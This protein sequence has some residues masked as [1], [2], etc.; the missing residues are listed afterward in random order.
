MEYDALNWKFCPKCHMTPWVYDIVN[1]M[2]GMIVT[3]GKDQ[4]VE[5]TEP[6]LKDYEGA[7]TGPFLALI[8]EGLLV[9]DH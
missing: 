3:S 7:E 1:L 5:V 2:S 8:G 4:S 9:D 6:R